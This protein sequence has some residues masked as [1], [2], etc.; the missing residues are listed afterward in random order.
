MTYDEFIQSKK[1][2]DPNTGFDIDRDLLNHHL[3]DFQRDIV[4]WAL[5]RGRACIFADCGLGKAIMQLEWSNQVAKHTGGM[6]LI[7]AP[8]AVSK[9]VIR[10][11]IKFGIDVELVSDNSSDAPIQST[12]YEKLHRFNLNRYVGI[13]L[14]ES[15]ILK[16]YTG[17]T[18]QSIIDLSIQ[19]P[20]R[21]ACTATPAPND[22]VELG[23]HCEFV[24]AMSRTEMLSMFFINDC[25]MANKWRLK[26]HAEKEFWKW[27]CSWAVMIRK[28]SDLGYDDGNYNLPPLNMHHEVV[29]VD[30]CDSMDGFLFRMPASSLKERQ[31]ERKITIADRAKKA[32]EIVAKHPDQQWLIWC[33]LNDEAAELIKSIPNSIEVSGS[34]SDE[35]KCDRMIGFSEGRYPIL[36]TKPKIAGHGMN[37]QNCCKIIF[38][39]LSDSYEQFYQSIRRCWR[40]G[41]TKPVDCYIVT[42]ETEGAVVSNIERKEKEAMNMAV[43]MVAN[44]HVYNEEN[45][46]G[47]ERKKSEYNPEKEMET[48]SF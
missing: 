44:M 3:F 42:A 46:R 5:K 10:E 47:I 38:V 11:G 6:V 19:I 40:F 14:D 17:K 48:P 13:V 45:I 20:Y 39:G 9:Q 25:D 16:S 37:W 34:H 23:T 22:F 33:N 32:A 8:L 4:R 12:N 27:V 21:L 15:S 28:P 30:E 31:T 7:V 1:C 43:E 36:V 41:Q 35:Q 2:I 29:S 24:G 18:C 26:G